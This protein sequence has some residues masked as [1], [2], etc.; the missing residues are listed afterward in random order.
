MVVV[1]VGC[2]TVVVVVGAAGCVAVVVTPWVTGT[3]LL[4]G[5]P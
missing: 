5:K 3:A 2:A 1:V 4:A